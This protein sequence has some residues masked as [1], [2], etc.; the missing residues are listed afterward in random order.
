MQGRA[1]KALCDEYFCCWNQQPPKEGG[2]S[3][4]TPPP[5][6]KTSYWKLA[7]RNQNLRFWKRNI[8]NLNYNRYNPNRT[9]Q[10]GNP[11]YLV[12]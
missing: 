11:E 8:Q 6:K 7:S 10:F 4:Y 12:F 5:H 9:L 3:F 1:R 2:G